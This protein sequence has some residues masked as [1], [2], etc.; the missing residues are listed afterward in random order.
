MKIRRREPCWAHLC[1]L[2]LKS[3]LFGGSIFLL[4]RYFFAWSSHSG[5]PPTLCMNLKTVLLPSRPELLSVWVLQHHPGSL[6]RTNAV[7][8]VCFLFGTVSYNILRLF[9]MPLWEW[10]RFFLSKDPGVVLTRG[11]PLLRFLYWNVWY[12]IVEL[13]G[14]RRC[15]P[16]EGGVSLSGLWGFHSQYDLSAPGLWN[17]CQLSAAAPAPAPCIPACYHASHYDDHGL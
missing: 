6:V 14:I 9:S 15:D 11:S 3:G 1:L 7:S 17:N 16:A 13:P 4:H 8:P 10:F 12:Q 5:V 2:Q